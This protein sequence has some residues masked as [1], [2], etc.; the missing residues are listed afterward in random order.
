MMQC[1]SGYQ[2]TFVIPLRHMA[3]VNRLSG[4]KNSDTWKKEKIEN[5]F[6]KKYKEFDDSADV[7]TTVVKEISTDGQEVFRLGGRVTINWAGAWF[8]YGE[9]ITLYRYVNTALLDI[10]WSGLWEKWNVFE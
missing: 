6:R 4:D 7:E 2:G 10:D 5:Y 8:R 1:Y 9:K 3:Y